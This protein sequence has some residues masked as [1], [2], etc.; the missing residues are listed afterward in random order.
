M[1]V[2]E[3][4]ANTEHMLMI[5]GKHLGAFSLHGSI[6]VIICITGHTMVCYGHGIII[7]HSSSSSSSK[8]VLSTCAHSACVCGIS[9]R[10]GAKMGR[11]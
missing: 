3:V 7:I 10:R 2:K 6:A 9:I 4:T 8:S 5:W 11:N 1:F